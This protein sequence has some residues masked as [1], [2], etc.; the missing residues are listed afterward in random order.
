MMPALSKQRHF[1]V[2]AYTAFPLCENHSLCTCVP[3]CSLTV[4]APLLCFTWWVPRMVWHHYAA[5]YS[6]HM[7]VV[8][9][10]CPAEQ[11][12]TRLMW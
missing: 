3:C 6:S 2:A 7:D 12:L 1:P 5:S 9:E 10:L 4:S 11:T 8:K